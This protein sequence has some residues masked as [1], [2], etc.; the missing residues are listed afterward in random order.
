[1]ADVVRDVRVRDVAPRLAFQAFGA[2]TEA[3]VEA[4]DRLTDAG[5]GAVEVSSFMRPDLIP[6][7]ADAEEVFARIRRPAGVSFECCIGNARGLE[8]AVAAGSDVA[9]FLL[10]IDDGFA[11]DNIGRSTED[12]LAELARL[13]AQAESLPITLG[14]YVIFAWGG[15]TGPP[16]PPGA[17]LDLGRRLLDIGVPDWVLADSIGYA[18]PDQVRETLEAVAVLN[19]LERLRLQIHDARG[20]GLANVLEAVRLGVT[21]ID[22]SLGGSGAHPALRSFR[23]SGVCTEDVV[24]LLERCHI[25]TGVNLQALLS[26]SR[27]FG[28]TVGVP[29]TG[30]TRNAGM[31]PAAHSAAPRASF[32]WA[33]DDLMSQ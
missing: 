15:P 24:Q 14:T 25:T 29:C 1:M 5:V 31:V 8:R 20:M 12:S 30:F 17:V 7:L 11:L 16:R 22:T 27:W 33:P 18:G 32:T 6:G 28:D 19:G 4:I 21:R 2:S 10:S 26:V 9:W 3:K 23:G 13:R